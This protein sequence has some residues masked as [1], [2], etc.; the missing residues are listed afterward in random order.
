MSGSLVDKLIGAALKNASNHK[1]ALPQLRLPSVLRTL[2]KDEAIGGKL[3]LG[4]TILALLV[5]NSELGD[6]Y[7][8][9]WHQHLTVGINQFVVSMSLQHWVSEGLMA[10]FFLVVGLEIKREFVKGELRHTKTAVLPIGAAIGGMLV[11]ALIFVAINNNQP[12]NIDGRAIPMAT[13]IAFA[14]GVLG[15]L[16]R[17]IPSS[18]RI[19]LLTLAIADDLG[20]IVVIALF[21]GAGIA[22]LP[23]LIALA[24]LVGMF[25]ARNKRFMTLP[26]FILGAFAVWVA[27]Y[28]SGI[29][30]SIA[31]AL[32]GF[33]ASL[34]SRHSIAERLEK[35]VIPFSTF[36]V[37]PLFAFAS[38]GI[39]LTS[40]FTNS[41]SVVLGAGIFAG[42]VL[43]KVVGITL[44]SWLLVK[45]K[46]A[47]LPRN[48]TWRQMFGVGL[49]A[50]IGFTVS[51]FIADLAF[52]DSESLT[53]TA[54]L[55][56]LLAS[57]V[58]AVAGYC[59]LR[60]GQ[61]RKQNRNA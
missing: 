6:T 21:Y 55:S 50:G 58:S 31:G 25:V 61:V 52:T 42:L 23:L 57:T 28:E 2:L 20:A 40:N 38:L 22:L 18:L 47:E 27:L 43:G 30:A 37:V 54:K 1:Y 14:L 60:Y 15:L 16:G 11:P 39:A 29:H 10:I 5:A 45:L 32:V 48:T 44:T 36:V 8:S 34:N 13:D 17:R 26:L 35:L 56:V 59:L 33:V 41:S 4:A 9:F 12:T 46:F 51:V 3:I 49:L 7:D 53:N 24:L 19:F